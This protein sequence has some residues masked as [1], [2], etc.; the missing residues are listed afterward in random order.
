M[1]LEIYL[2][3]CNNMSSLVGWKETEQLR[4]WRNLLRSSCQKKK[5][6]YNEGEKNKKNS[7]NFFGEKTFK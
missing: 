6:K 2:R 5:K 3:K 4:G 7:S 1:K